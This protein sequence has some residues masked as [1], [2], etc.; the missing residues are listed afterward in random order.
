MAE[1]ILTTAALH[2]DKW[3]ASHPAIFPGKEC[4]P[5]VRVLD[6]FHM[7]SGCND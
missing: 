3:S 1:K 7:L 6:K 2:E 5:L 4:Y